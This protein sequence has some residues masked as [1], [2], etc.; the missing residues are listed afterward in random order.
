MYGILLKTSVRLALSACEL[1]R[2]G[3]GSTKSDADDSAF[4]GKFRAGAGR[5]L[6][7]LISFAVSKE[8]TVKVSVW[9]KLD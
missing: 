3:V 8:W 9:G 2:R 4:E 5:C 1:P 7:R 6:P